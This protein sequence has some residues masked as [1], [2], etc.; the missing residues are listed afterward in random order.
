MPLP[1]NF[2]R[3]SHLRSVYLTTHNRRVRAEFADTGDDNW[4]PDITTTR[5]SL[6]V[7]CTIQ[8]TDSATIADMRC[9]LFYDVLEH[10]ASS[11]GAFYGIPT[12]LY[13]ESVRIQPQVWMYFRE[14]K[15]SHMESG[16]R[17]RAEGEQSF[18]L[19]GLKPEDLT[20]ATAQMLATRI[21]TE[22]AAGGGFVWNKGKDCY[23]YFDEE[24]RLRFKILNRTAS[25]AEEIARK[26]CRVI[27]HTFQEKYGSISPGSIDRYP[28]NPPNKTILGKSR[29]GV[30]RRP[31]ASVRF[32]YAVLHVDGI[33]TPI[34]LCDRVGR[35]K[36]PLVRA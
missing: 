23:Y 27:G 25:H 35:H 21:A 13:N 24:S 11:L 5:G 7:A 4:S 29:S 22:Y 32:Q 33:A 12:A 18:R 8:A 20:M 16:R 6:R 3:W 17:T 36:D 28:E 9:R 31:I 10:G 14:D 1:S 34:V 26:H 30:I 2:N 15:A 19:P